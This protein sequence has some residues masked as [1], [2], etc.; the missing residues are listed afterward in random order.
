MK[1]HKFIVLLADG[2]ADNPDESLGGMTVLE[3]APTPNMDK[4]ARD[5]ICGL[6]RTVPEGMNP[7]SDTA[8]LAIFGYNPSVYYTGRAPFEALSMGVTLSGDDVAFR[9][10]IVNASNGVMNSFTSDHIESEYSKLVIEELSKKDSFFEYHAGVSYRNIAVWRKFPF[11]TLP[12]TTPPHDIQTQA[13]APYLPKGEGSDELQRSMDISREAVTLARSRAAAKSYK[14]DPE[15]VWLWGCGKKPLLT[16]FQEKFG[17]TGV[18]ISAVD[19]IHGIGIAAGLTPVKVEGATGYLDTNYAGK[20]S[21]ALN[22]LEEHD[23][24]YLHVE[25]P[26]E[27][28]HEGNLSHKLQAVSDFDEK[29]VGPM[30]EGLSRFTYTVLIMPDHPTPFRIRTHTPDPIPFAVF[31]N[32]GK[33][34]FVGTKSVDSYSERQARDSGIYLDK[35]WELLEMI[36]LGSSKNFSK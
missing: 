25:A 7:G 31:S 5:G 27:S 11:S 23:F 16:P 24:V 1:K 6:A 18:T 34:P 15:S 2:M 9:M 21:A 4:C 13:I 14:G 19:L 32:S 22:A 20:V 36:I 3:Y 8:N 29:V 35:G 12:V 26:D 17:I 33:L 30:I 10:N 28:G